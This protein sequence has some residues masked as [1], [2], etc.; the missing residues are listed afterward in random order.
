MDRYEWLVALGTFLAVHAAFA[1]W[2][3]MP[4]ALLPDTPPS[5]HV[6][7]AL[8]AARPTVLVA[9]EGDVLAEAGVLEALRAEGERPLVLRDGG[10]AS[11]HLYLA[12]KNGV[13]A[14]A[15]GP[16][17]VLYGIRRFEPTYPAYHAD[18]YQ[19]AILALA[20]PEEPDLERLLYKGRMPAWADWLDRRWSLWRARGA[21]RGRILTGARRRAGAWLAGADSARTDEAWRRLLVRDGARAEAEARARQALLH[22]TQDFAVQV[23]RSFLPLILAETRRL[24]CRLVVLRIGP[25]S[26]A[27]AYDAAL[28]DYLARRGVPL[29]AWPATAVALDPETG[30]NTGGQV[31][32]RAAAIGA[33]RRAIRPVP[34]GGPA[35]GGAAPAGE[36]KAD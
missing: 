33:L 34:G 6:A 32:P 10:A 14:S 13:A 24:G 31:D 15:A 12:L 30:A 4:P 29:V 7:R 17:V 36:D 9:G 19:E 23:T 2:R 21:V 3:P 35:V 8:E 11:A 16:E 5:P 18:R 20:G 1:A 22:P 27:A 28:A 25:G 26:G